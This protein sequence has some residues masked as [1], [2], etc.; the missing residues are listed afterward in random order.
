M[1]KI[2][3]QFF[4]AH[5]NVKLHVKYPNAAKRTTVYQRVYCTI[6][7]STFIVS[8]LQHQVIYTFGRIYALK[9]I[10]VGHEY[11]GHNVHT[12]CQ[13]LNSCKICIRAHTL[14]YLI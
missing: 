9:I 3:E 7:T 8:D 14:L 2:L 10:T 6:N 4:F 12:N 11:L 1:G 13:C 5:F